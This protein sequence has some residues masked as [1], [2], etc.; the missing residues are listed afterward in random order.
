M[1]TILTSLWHGAK[2]LYY[3]SYSDIKT[4][5]LPV[6]AFSLSIVPWSGFI[7]T[8]L[9]AFWLQSLIAE[10]CF[11][12]QSSAN[13]L[14]EDINNKPYRPIPSGMMTL[15]TAR[16]IRWFMPFFNIIQSAILGSRTTVYATISLSII[17]WIHN[18]LEVSR[19]FYAKNFLAGACFPALEI[20]CMTVATAGQA[21]NFHQI[22]SV[23][24]STLVNML[25]MHAQ[26]FPDVVGDAAAGRKTFPLVSPWGARVFLVTVLCLS[27]VGSIFISAVH[28]TL[29]W[30]QIAFLIVTCGRYLLIR[31][32]P[33]REMISYWIYDFWLAF[34]HA[35]LSK[36]N[37]A[38]VPITTQG[39]V[40]AVQAQWI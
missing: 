39:F 40:Q 36:L 9:T 20:G 1:S 2:V 12:N 3:L 35:C 11:S 17:L 28:P 5:T 25:T 32:Q 33:K 29:I 4:V 16:R 37:P 8:L 19:K 27:T 15:K 26:D 21:L 6:L 24:F 14:A 34:C 10:W 38:V 7:R 23:V 18:D 22:V 30:L 31:N 13:A